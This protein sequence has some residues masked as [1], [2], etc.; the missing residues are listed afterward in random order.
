MAIT[1][2]KLTPMLNT[3]NYFYMQIT[4]TQRPMLFSFLHEIQTAMN[5]VLIRRNSEIQCKDKQAEIAEF[6]SSGAG[7]VNAEIFQKVNF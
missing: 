6:G 7:N 4:V 3:I 5:P 2:T 1:E